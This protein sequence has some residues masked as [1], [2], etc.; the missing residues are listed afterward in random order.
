MNEDS[1]ITH[2]DTFSKTEKSND[3][4]S[5]VCLCFCEKFC[6]HLCGRNNEDT[7]SDDIEYALV[8]YVQVNSRYAL[9]FSTIKYIGS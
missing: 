7:T 9:Q 6:K 8:R 2:Y 1:G 5:P 4:H 3:G